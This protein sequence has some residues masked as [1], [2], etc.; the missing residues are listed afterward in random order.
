MR[1]TAGKATIK[2]LPG[3]RIGHGSDFHGLTGCT[4]I[5]SEAGAVCGVDLRGSAAGTRELAPCLPGHIVPRVHAVLLTG[6]S[7]FGLDAAAGVMQ[8][9]ESHGVGFPAG[10]IRVPIVPAAVVFD[11]NLGSAKARPDAGMALGACRMATS[12]VAEG[13]LGAG[14]G[15]TV[16]KLLGIKQATKGGLGFG[17]LSLAN[18]ATVQALAVVNAFGDVVD[19]GSGKI[20]AGARTSPGS[21]EFAGTARLMLQGKIRK[22]FGGTN[23]TLVVVMTNAALDKVQATK[24]AQMAQ[25][26]LARA[27]CPVHTQFDGDLVFALSLG[28]KRADLNTLGTAAAQV[29]SMAIVRAIETAK[30]LGGVP[31]HGELRAAEKK[32]VRCP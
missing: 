19:P 18:G 5:L 22:G 31:A 16:G 3:F 13:S 26:G 1:G 28:S 8:H 15:V 20:L 23:T 30:G 9:L 2:T 17:T 12:V 6:G 25:D 29:T 27:I 21:W 4:V 14:T 10:R 32:E 24:V 7:A 11:L